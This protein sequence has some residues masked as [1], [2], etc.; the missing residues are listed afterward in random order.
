MLELSLSTASFKFVVINIALFVVLVHGANSFTRD[1]FPPGFVFG[2]GSSAYQAG[3]RSIKPRW[4]DSK[5]MGYLCP[6]WEYAWRHRR[7]SM[8]WISQVQDGKGAINPKGLLYYNNLISELISY[9]IQPHVTLHHY[10]LPQVLE[11]EYGGWVSRKIVKDFTGYADVCFREFDDR[12]KYWTTVNEANVFALGG[13][14]SGNMPPG[15]CS[16]PFGVVDNCSAGSSST[17]P[18]LVTH[19]ILLGHASAA[20]LYEKRYKDKQHGFIGMNIFQYWFVPFTNSI[21]DKIAAQRA[22]DFY[23]GWYLNPL[24][25]GDYPEIVKKN[26]GSRF[27]AFTS[28]ESKRIKGSFYFIGVNYYNKMHV[29]EKSSSLKS[30]IRDF[31]AD[32][33]VELIFVRNESA[34]EMKI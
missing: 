13:Y 2:A 20:R 31:F 10:D 33:G 28:P 25:F 8:L 27:P 12:V 15:R 1:D 23:I 16:S 18:Y 11:N 22:K 17:E 21:T 32:T 26:V 19:H 7:C 9:G 4:K 34:Y 30:K 14:D 6:S 5:H 3:G 29:K 24:I